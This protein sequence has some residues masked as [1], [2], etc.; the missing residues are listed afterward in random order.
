MFKKKKFSFF[1]WQGGERIVDS[2]LL[3]IPGK[4][5]CIFHSV[6]PGVPGLI[7]FFFDF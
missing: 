6:I 3:G 2:R 1:F 5:I 4:Y 7:G